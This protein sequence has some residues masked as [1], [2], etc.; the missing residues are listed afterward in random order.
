[1]GKASRERVIEK[2]SLENM[3]SQIEATYHQGLERHQWVAAVPRFARQTRLKRTTSLF[4]QRVASRS[5][6]NALLRSSLLRQKFLVLCYHGVLRRPPQS[7]SSYV[8]NTDVDHFEDQMRFLAKNFHLVSASELIAIR[9]GKQSLKPRSAMVTF[10]DGYENNLTNA[11]PILRTFNIPAVFHVSTG[12]I[13]GTQLLWPDEVFLR[14]LNWSDTLLPLPGGGVRGMP[15]DHVARTRTAENVRE[16]CKLIPGA[17]LAKYI[18]MLQSGGAL[19]PNKTDQETYRFMNWDQVRE[20]C[21]LGFE[22]GSHTVTHPILSRVPDSQLEWE[23]RESK[24]RIEAELN[25]E[26][27]LLAYPNGLQPDARE[28]TWKAAEAAGY[29]FGFMLRRGLSSLRNTMAINRIN[30]PGD[31][32]KVVFESRAAGIYIFR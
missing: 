20:L 4:I 21:R 16:D 8:I 18:A 23:L 31:E 15:Q 12:Y 17:V 9:Q 10:D 5:G 13:G 19:S 14:V 32:S 26:C 30:I 28:A 7:Y 2:F 11:A 6:V 22:I 1:M 25:R 3:S 24:H 29:T 27:R